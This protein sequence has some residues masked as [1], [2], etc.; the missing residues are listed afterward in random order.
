MAEVNLLDRYPRSKRPIVERG[1]RKL[2]GDGK[3]YIKTEN[4]AN[5]DIYVEQLLLNVAR[6]F[7]KEYFDGDRLYG[8]G[9]YFYDPRYWTDT[10][11]RFRE[12]YH[13]GDNA[14]ILDVGCAKGFMLYDFKKLMPNAVIAGLDISTYAYEHAPDEI[15]PYITVGNAK[16]LPH[17]DR[18]FD[19]VISI[20]TVDHLPLDECKQAICEIQRVTREHSFIT[21]N[22]W[23]NE[24]EKVN[25]LKWNI[26]ASTYMHIDDWGKLFR[27][28]GYKGDYYWFIAE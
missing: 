2:S 20:N 28:V 13:L 12:Y 16:E 7:G 17:P 27:E 10:A 5:Q 4:R 22:A 14:S 11:K 23:R 1:L 9:G 26:T 6:R 25:L 18:S 3:I 21:V 8:Y 19:L 24:I 15:R